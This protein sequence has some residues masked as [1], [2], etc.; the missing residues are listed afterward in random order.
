[1]V[2]VAGGSEAAGVTMFRRMHGHAACF[3]CDLFQSG[4]WPAEA[5][6]QCETVGMQACA[7]LTDPSAIEG[8]LV[9]VARGSCAFNVKADV[10]L[11]SGASA[12]IVGNGEDEYVVMQRAAS[13]KMAV[14]AGLIPRPAFRFLQSLLQSGQPVRATF[15]GEFDIAGLDSS[16]SMD[17]SSSRG[18]T[19]DG[20]IKP[21]L[22][23]PG[24]PPVMPQNPLL[25]P[26][27]W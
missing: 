25:C 15:S 10:A 18:P 12:V 2:G 22:V 23:A 8:A 27:F 7:E 1:M 16:E 17:E 5:E 11:R 21:D 20:R 19:G 26:V 13:G 9:L 3:S 24:A 6:G 14:P 4:V